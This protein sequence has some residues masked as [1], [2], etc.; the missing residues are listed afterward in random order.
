MGASDHELKV[1]MAQG[2]IQAALEKYDCQLV[3]IGILLDGKLSHNEI[4]VVPKRPL[5]CQVVLIPT[6]A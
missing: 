4:R 1:R 5:S 3:A 2:D 6:D